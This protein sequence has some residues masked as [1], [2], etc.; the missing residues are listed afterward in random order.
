MERIIDLSYTITDRMPVYP[1][2]RD[3]SLEQTCT[4]EKD[5]FNAFY[6]QTGLHAGTHIDIPY[7]ML[8]SNCFISEYPPSRFIGNGVLLDVRGEKVIK[9]K[10]QYNAK[11]SE[12][13]IVILYTGSADLLDEPLRYYKDYPVIDDELT[14]FFINKRIKLLGMDT[15]AP[16]RAPFNTHKALLENDIPILENLTDLSLLINADR[17]DIHAVPL[18]IEAEAS[19]VRAYAVLR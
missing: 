5:N 17:F 6:L 9:Y 13:D 8:D 10:S 1:N 16:D 2:D 14:D 3:V 11:V 4:L 15:P 12:N 19:L 7:H 18:K